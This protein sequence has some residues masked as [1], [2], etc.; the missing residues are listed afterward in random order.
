MKGWSTAQAL[1]NPYGFVARSTPTTNPERTLPALPWS[2]PA[3]NRVEKGQIQGEGGP[4]PL[5]DCLRLSAR[6]DRA[7][8][9]IRHHGTYGR[10][11]PHCCW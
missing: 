2:S 4:L 1:A 8:R 11:A 3:L 9:W 7:I 5:R 6:S 10:T